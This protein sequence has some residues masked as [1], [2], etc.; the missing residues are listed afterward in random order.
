MTNNEINSRII[1]FDKKTMK[2]EETGK[3]SVMYSV[4]YEVQTSPYTN[5]Y[6]PTVLNSYASEG[7]FDILKANLGKSVK[8]ELEEKPVFGKANTYKKVVSKVD[9]KSVR[10]F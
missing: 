5:H 7:A 2:D 3:V 1:N 8:I 9:G 10:Q 6:G 4:N